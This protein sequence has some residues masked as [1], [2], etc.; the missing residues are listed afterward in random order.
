MVLLNEKRWIFSD[1]G[2][3]DSGMQSHRQRRPCNGIDKHQ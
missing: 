1:A 3:C 2:F